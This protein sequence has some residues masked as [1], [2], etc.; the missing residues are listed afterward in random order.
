M[1]TRTLLT[2]ACVLISASTL[3]AQSTVR[4]KT[5]TGY[6]TGDGV[7][8]RARPAL[9]SDT[10][11]VKV[12]K[13]TEV[14]VV[15]RTS[16]KWL[17]VKPVPGTFSA[18][19]E[20]FVKL[21]ANQKIGTITDDNVN[22]RAGGALSTKG[23][24]DYVQRP[25]LNE[26]DKV[27]VFAKSGDYYLIVPPPGAN[28]FISSDYVVDAATWKKMAAEEKK[29]D[30]TETTHTGVV[31]PRTTT[32]PADGNE[33]VVKVEK[34]AKEVAAVVAQWKEA[35][36][37]LKEE[38]AKP[39]EKRDLKG[40][41]EKYRAIELSE[42]SYLKPYVAY[43]LSFLNTQ[44][45][46][47]EE[48]QE[49]D[50]MV[51]KTQ[52]QQ[53][54]LRLLRGKIEENVPADEP[55]TEYAVSGVLRESLLFRGGATGAKRYMVL[56]T[57]GKRIKAYVRSTGGLVDLSRYV[58]KHVG[59]YGPKKFD[60]KLSGLYIVEAESVKVLKDSADLPEEPKARVKNPSV[61]IQSP[62]DPKPAPEP[63]TRPARPTFGPVIEEVEP[64]TGTGADEDADKEDLPETGLP[65]IKGTAIT[66]VNE[67]E[68]N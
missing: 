60:K 14:V 52:A 5:Y 66:P 26:G 65:L 51:K 30:T 2:A 3:M 50:E 54:R 40:V 8:V 47:R 58:G 48:L 12:D 64:T 22:I 38:Y 21:G 62:K 36:K 18:V 37:A 46:Q 31:K 39:Y 25:R 59:I 53:E 11:C 19:Y 24:F 29:P 45:E 41:M 1:K 55:V 27:R 17:E 20:K 33:P 4:E 61:K 67:A 35:E 44:I 32:Q 34:P 49:I 7:Y 28:F 23:R 42:N 10:R 15:S 63:T 13:G 16:G 9:T 68:Y 56:G 43:R 57:D 6:V